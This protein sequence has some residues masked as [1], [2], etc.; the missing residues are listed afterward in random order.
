MIRVEVTPDT[1]EWMAER[2]SSIG[3][4]EVAAAVGESSYDGTP[5]SV[6][7]SKVGRPP[8]FDPLLSLI[9]HGAEPIISDWVEDYHPEV[10]EVGPGFMARNEDYPWLHATFDRVVTDPDGVQVPL[11]LKTSTVFVRHKW[12]LD[13]PVDYRI[14]EEIECL[15]MGAPY[16]LLAVWHTGT[17]EFE[18]YRLPAHEDRQQALAESTRA[19][20]EHI[21][22]RTPPPPTLGDDLA[23]MFP[24]SADKQVVADLEMVETVEFL[25]ETA[26]MRNSTVREYQAQE[27]D[28]KFLL[29]QFMEDAVELIHPHTGQVIH[30]WKEQKNGARRHYTPRSK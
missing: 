27:A 1:P 15:V 7:L 24:A 19:L 16:A 10:G 6:Y 28:A 9:G 17:T 25:R 21:D 18:L 30:T 13:V 22:T 26:A 12:D 29:E 20:W 4:S 2:R 11:Q 14:Q 3:A 8:R 23:A 5:L